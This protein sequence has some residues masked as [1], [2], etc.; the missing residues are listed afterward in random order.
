MSRATVGGILLM[1][2]SMVMA[3]IAFGV[4]SA[5]RGGGPAVGARGNGS[6]P[7][8][9]VWLLIGSAGVLFL[10]GL[11]LGCMGSRNCAGG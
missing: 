10:W 11:L 6:R 8:A 7:T 4:D 9:V 1:L 3:L 2:A 5:R